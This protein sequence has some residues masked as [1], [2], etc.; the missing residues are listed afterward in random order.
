M[1]F[2]DPNVTASEELR[3]SA[4]FLVG[5]EE[6]QGI[7]ALDLEEHGLLMRNISDT[8][9]GVAEFPNNCHPLSCM[10]AAWKVYPIFKLQSEFTLESGSFEVYDYQNWKIYI[11]FPQQNHEQFLFDDAS[12]N[13]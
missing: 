4:G 7:K 10:I 11:H 12:R 1:Y 5:E 3:W 6:A 9:T 8:D 13:K 2:D